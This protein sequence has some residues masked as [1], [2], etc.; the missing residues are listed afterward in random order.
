M[1]GVVVRTDFFV[2]FS[3]D[4]AIVRLLLGDWDDHGPAVSDFVNW[5]D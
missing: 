2:K 5:C 3:D 1:A 4:T